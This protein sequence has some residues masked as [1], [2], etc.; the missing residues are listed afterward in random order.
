MRFV[1]R[2]TIYSLPNASGPKDQPIFVAQH[3][4]TFSTT[5]NF[6]D[7]I[8]KNTCGTFAKIMAPYEVLRAKSEDL[9]G[10]TECLLCY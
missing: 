8:N 9:R 5:V 4:C 2:W 1:L 10:I 6:G 3:R 7:R